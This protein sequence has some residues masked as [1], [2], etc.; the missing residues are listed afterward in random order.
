MQQ[1]AEV[2]LRAFAPM[3][4]DDYV[5]ALIDGWGDLQRAEINTP[6]R[7]CEFLAQTAHETGGYRILAESTSWS[8]KRMCEIWPNRF[9]TSVDPRILACGKD[10]EKL[11][12]LAYGTG[13]LARTLG[14][15]E[16]GD[17]WLFRGRGFLQDTGRS[18]YREMGQLVGIDFEGNPELM[19][20]PALS[21]RSAIARWHKMG[22]N[23]FADRHYTRAIGNAINRGS[24][25]RSQ[26]PIGAKGRLEWFDRAWAVFGDAPV[27]AVPPGM[28]L[29]AY[30]P[31]V[32]AVQMRLKELGYGVGTVDKVFGPTLSRAVVAFKVDHKLRT[33][34]DLEPD[35]IVA[36]LTEAALDVG[37]PVLISD[38]RA[39]ATETDLAAAGSQ[40]VKTGQEAKTAGWVMVG[41]GA[42]E[43]ARQSGGLDAMQNQLQWVPS[44]HSFMVPVIEAVK[45]G[46][47]NAFWVIALAGGA[48]F[49]VKGRKIITERLKA[50]TSGMNLFR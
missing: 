35:E 23:R 6:L 12:N 24:P 47:Q 5:K 29:G 9:K 3:A 15:T 26:E 44:A 10:P 43:G 2:E 14:N 30:G 25:Y 1:W 37:Q 11:A 8:A 19:S 27:P 45:W 42:V 33:G 22:L 48:W 4:R 28:A 39:S 34:Q 20:N 41:T 46:F 18:A 40:E 7:L 21:L 16:N 38:E 17:G 13:D 31:K 50:H 49:W 32:E 36:G